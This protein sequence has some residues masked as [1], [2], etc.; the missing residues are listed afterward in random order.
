[1]IEELG[2]MS[3]DEHPIKDA[4]VTF[5]SFSLFGLMPCIFIYLTKNSNTIHC[6][7]YSII[8]RKSVCNFNSF[9]RIFFIHT[10]CC[11]INVF[12]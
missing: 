6:R 7:N 2:L 12:L 1:M 5:V 3:I 10:W 8:R 9:N 11:K 4:I